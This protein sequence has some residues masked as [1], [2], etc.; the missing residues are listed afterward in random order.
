MLAE[1]SSGHF[2][3]RACFCARL[4]WFFSTG[5]WA[6]ADALE[7][8]ALW[9]RPNKQNKIGDYVCFRHAFIPCDNGE[10]RCRDTLIAPALY[11]AMVTDSGSP[12]K[13]AMLFFTHLRASTWSF[14]PLL[15][16][17]SLSPVLKN[18]NININL[19]I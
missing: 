16:G 9:K 5:Y 14:S 10:R 17:A 2:S 18:P 11:P 12:P 1:V 15:P 3:S 19:F 13:A 4:N 8:M 6:K 7:I